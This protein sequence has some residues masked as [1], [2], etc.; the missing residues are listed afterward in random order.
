MITCELVRAYMENG[1]SAANSTI[2]KDVANAIGVLNNKR[3]R[4]CIRGLQQGLK[5]SG[6]LVRTGYGVWSI[7]FS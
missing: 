7:V 4:H 1:G 6:L 2:Y 3:F 5:R